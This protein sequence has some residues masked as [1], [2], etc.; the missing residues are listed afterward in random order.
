MAK[1]LDASRAKKN[2]KVD[3]YEKAK[4]EYEK[5]EDNDCKK[6]VVL[7]KLHFLEDEIKEEYKK[8]L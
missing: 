7:K 4:E 8:K 3:E 2:G 1:M 6:K 5:M